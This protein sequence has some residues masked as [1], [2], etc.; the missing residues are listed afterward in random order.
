[1]SVEKVKKIEIVALKRIKQELLEALQH[2]GKVHIAGITD[3]LPDATTIIP[4]EGDVAESVDAGWLGQI[5]YTINYLNKFDPL[6]KGF[7]ESLLCL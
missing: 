6:P 5:H 2:Q 1:M 3:D 7:L 4:A